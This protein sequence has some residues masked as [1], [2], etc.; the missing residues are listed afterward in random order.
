MAIGVSEFGSF[1]GKRVDQF[2]LT[3]DTGVEVDLISY[4][5][6]VRDWRVPVKGGLRSVV[7][8]FDSFEPYV[9]DSPHFGCL[10]GRVANRIKGASFELDGRTYTTPTNFEDRHT[11]HGGPEGLGRINWTG[12]A[13]SAANA[14]RFTHVSPDGHM[15]FPG[16][17]TFTAT[18]TLTGNRLRLEIRAKTDTRTPINVVQ[19]QYFNLGT[20]SDIL[21]HRYQITAS[22][23]TELDEDLIP[24]G[25]ILPVAGTIWDF[26]TARTMRDADGAPIDFDGNLVLASARRFDDPIATVTGPDGALTLKLWSDKPGVQL[27]N[28]VWTDVDAGGKVFKKHAGFCLEDQDLPDA[29]HNPHFPS[30]IC[31]PDRDY[32]HRCDIEIG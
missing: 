15:G 18:Y 32:T 29:L 28:S 3:S 2:K 1:E 6:A 21:D 31:G 30:I 8:G 20:T 16:T 10:A 11:L 7:L 26:N 22:A 19:H 17:V 14:V 5:V 25:G 9:S 24:T 4:G 12:E 13:D 23:Y 27:Y